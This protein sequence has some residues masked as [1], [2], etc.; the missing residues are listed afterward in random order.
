MDAGSGAPGFGT[1]R[2]ACTAAATWVRTLSATVVH[3]TVPS[4][5]SPIAPPTC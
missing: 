5:A 1:G 4:S 3:A 2:P